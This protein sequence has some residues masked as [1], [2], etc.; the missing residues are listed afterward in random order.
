M[1]ACV[2]D[3]IKSAPGTLLRPEYIFL[4]LVVPGPEHPGRKLNI[5]M[6]PLV[7][8]FQKL[9]DGVQTWD[10]SLKQNFTMKAMYLWSVHDFVA[11]GDFVGWSTHG[12]L[13]CPYEYDCRGFTLRHGRKPSW[14]DCHR[15]FLPK[16]HVFRKQANS[17]WKNTKVFDDPPRRLTREEIQAKWINLQVIQNTVVNYT[18]G[19]I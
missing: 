7:D 9:W 5:L 10:A 13:A 16:S 2:Y 19:H 12:R 15:R 6:Q 4:A 14:F 11:Y 8:E 3:P 18:I 1:L 17:F